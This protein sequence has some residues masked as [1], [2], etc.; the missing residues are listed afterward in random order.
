MIKKWV[1]AAIAYLVLVVAVFGVY[2]VTADP[3]PMDMKKTEQPVQKE[4]MKDKV[5]M[6]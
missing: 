1:L 5:E 4:Q 3:E 2:N 6:D